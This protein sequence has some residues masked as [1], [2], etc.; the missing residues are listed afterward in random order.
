MEL[1]QI[2]AADLA[3]HPAF[4]D[5]GNSGS[6]KD[7]ATSELLDDIERECSVLL[8]LPKERLDEE[9]ASRILPKFEQLKSLV[10]VNTTLDV[11]F[12]DYAVQA[13]QRAIDLLHSGLRAQLKGRED[14]HAEISAQGRN[15]ANALERDGFCR[16]GADAALA[17]RVWRATWWERSLLRKRA[18]MSPGRHA[19]IALHDYSPASL[20][21]QRAIIN[22]GVLEAASVYLG[23]PMQFVY[24][25]LDY[26]HEEQDWYK[27]CYA[28]IGLPTSRTVYMH[29]DADSEMM[30]AMFYLR[31][32]DAS[33]GPFRYVRG[34]HRWRRSA[35]QCAL[36]KAFD[37]Q[38]ADVFPLEADGLDYSLGYYRPRYKLPEYRRGLMA[39]PSALRG[40]THFGDDVLDGSALSEGLL[41]QEETFIGPAGTLVLFDGSRGIHRGSQVARGERWAIQ[42]GMRTRKPARK[43]RLPRPFSTLVNMGR[44]HLERVRAVVAARSA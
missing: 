40:S 31:D 30:K 22:N 24:A 11:P 37:E 1:T 12:R 4:R 15:Y 6:A 3:H 26:S 18:R 34:S 44:Y 13:I 42:I 43:G 7:T 28:D 21:I 33:G 35:V 10:M 29:F 27:G 19:V 14:T 5:L 2:P 25:A 39:L 23:R 32:V 17:R 36:D 38:Q 9:F 16:I 20:S 8:S 41:S